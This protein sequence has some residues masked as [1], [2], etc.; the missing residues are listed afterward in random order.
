MTCNMSHKLSQLDEDAGG[1]WLDRCPPWT[2]LDAGNDAQLFDKLNEGATVIT[3]LVQSLV[4]EDDAGNVV[5]NFLR[6]QQD[7]YEASGKVAYKYM[8]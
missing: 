4:E 5:A 2:Y 1:D 6:I 8:Y 3:L 7:Y